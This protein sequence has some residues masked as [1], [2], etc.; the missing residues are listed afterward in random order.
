MGIGFG[1][2]NQI[3]N[4]V[5]ASGNL[6]KPKGKI[7]FQKQGNPLTR[8]TWDNYLTVSESDAKKIGLISKENLFSQ[9]HLSHI[10]LS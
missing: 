4:A 2:Q 1:A 7:R 5:S 3:I 6:G 10:M 8:A 9:C